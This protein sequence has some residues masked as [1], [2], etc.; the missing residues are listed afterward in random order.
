MVN[1]LVY[2]VYR[3]RAGTKVYSSTGFQAEPVRPN[4]R[5]FT[6]QIANNCLVRKPNWWNDFG[7]GNAKV[8]C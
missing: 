8:Y 3:N 4:N 1:G 7:C 6:M 2:D 5:F